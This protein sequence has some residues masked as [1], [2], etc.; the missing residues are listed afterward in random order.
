MHF[1]LCLTHE[2]TERFIRNENHSARKKGKVNHVK[3]QLKSSEYTL[4]P[5]EIKKIIYSTKTFRD[6]CLIEALYYAGLRRFEAQ[7]LDV[8]DID[9]ERKRI[10]VRRGKGE[11][12]RVIPILNDGFLSDL[13]HLTRD[14]TQG[15][16]FLSTRN[17]KLS[18]RAINKIVAGGGRL[19]QVQNPDPARKKINPHLFRHSIAR[20]LKDQGFSVEFVQKFLGH[21]SFKTTMDMYGT[22]SIDDM[23]EMVERKMTPD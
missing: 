5:S 23:Q 7:N 2:P 20:H 12:V 15:Y 1:F 8:R 19:A 21:E 22:L 16:V 3:Q 18:L 4:K 6:R 9:F 10:T 17:N 14:R 13:R 11:K